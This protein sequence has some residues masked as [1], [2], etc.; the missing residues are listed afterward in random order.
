LRDKEIN[1]KNNLRMLVGETEN[2]VDEHVLDKKNAFIAKLKKM[3]ELNLK[4]SYELAVDKIK[5]NS[6]KQFI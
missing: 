4:A 2:D 5:Y 3:K 6:Y 1:E